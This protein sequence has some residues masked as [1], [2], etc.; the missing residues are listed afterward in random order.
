MLDG[1]REKGMLGLALTYSGGAN[2][3]A[4]KRRLQSPADLKGLKVG[5]YGHAVDEAWLR[6]LGA[7]PV[8]IGHRTQDI[9]KKAKAGE[10]DAVVTT[11]PNYSREELET[12]LPRVGLMGSSYLVS[13]TFINEK[14]FKTLPARHQALLKK[15][16][17]EVA[18]V[19]RARTIELNESSRLTSVA[20]GATSDQLSDD[21]RRAFAKAVEPAYEKTIS[22][23]IGGKLVEKI[24][25][26][27]DGPAHAP[28]T[29]D[30]AGR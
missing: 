5:V 3:V 1:L 4:S 18:R 25:R 26:A 22:K 12:V 9:A 27:L 15:A 29:P 24:R 21:E 19:E 8:A 11:W 23:T 28:A 6:E 14:F 16:A 10:L 7:T 2:G 20:K 30:F 13:V 17:L